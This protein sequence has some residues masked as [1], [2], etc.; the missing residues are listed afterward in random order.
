[1]YFLLYHS[2]IGSIARKTRLHL[3]VGKVSRSPGLLEV[4]GRQMEFRVAVWNGDTELGVVSLWQRSCHMYWNKN[5][6][7]IFFV[8]FRIN[9]KLLNILS[10]VPPLPSA[11]S[12]SWFEA[13]CK[14]PR[15]GLTSSALPRANV[16]DTSSACPL[17]VLC[18]HSS[19]YIVSLHR[20]GMLSL[21][22]DLILSSVSPPVHI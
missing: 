1:M 10:T 11:N 12:Y 14:H 20:R 15:C 21:P 22:W 2:I 17:G 13:S 16:R 18:H 4:L 8:D 5:V 7:V 6:A 19:C 3:C 9:S